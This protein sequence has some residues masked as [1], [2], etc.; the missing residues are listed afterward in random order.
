[1]EVGPRD[2]LQNEAV[3]V[4]TDVKVELVGRLVSAGLRRIEVTSFVSPQAVPQ[5]ADAEKVMERLPSHA[6]VRYSGLIVNERGLERA[7]A[8]GVDEVNF[9]LLATETFNRRNQGKSTSASIAEWSTV[10]QEAEASGLRT[11]VTIGAAFGCPFEGRVSLG[12]LTEVISEVL[13]GAHPDELCLADTIGIGVPSQVH[14]RLDLAR[15]LGDPIKLRC[16]FHN[17]RNT[18]YANAWAAVES[19]V[20]ALDSSVGG[21]GGCP[22]SPDATG[23]VA[24][25]DLAHL[26]ERSGHDPGV[27]VEALRGWSDWLEGIV[28]HTVPALLPKA[29]RWPPSQPS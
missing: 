27:D 23:N 12:R 25:E 20:D 2:G 8:T 29:S 9:V 24:T 3:H 4:P 26:L 1:M 18:G 6:D 21:I 14:R 16:H 7:L 19:G 28:E 13:E 10:A 11:T 17:T 5:M 15:S 22:F